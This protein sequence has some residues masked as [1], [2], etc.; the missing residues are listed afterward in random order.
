V[1]KTAHFDENQL[2][3][4]N[5]EVNSMKVEMQNKDVQRSDNQQ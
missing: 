2:L 5:K 4:K 3:Q 1:N